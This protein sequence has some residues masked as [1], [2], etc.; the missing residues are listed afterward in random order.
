MSERGGQ[1]V[2]TQFVTMSCPSVA[3]WGGGGQPVSKGSGCGLLP[4]LLQQTV[5]GCLTGAHVPPSVLAACK[6]IWVYYPRTLDRAQVRLL[7]RV[8]GL[9]AR[10][11]HAVALQSS[12]LGLS[13]R[14]LIP[15]CFPFPDEGLQTGL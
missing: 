8:R 4:R 5:G 11:R 15:G 7:D 13:A 3:V 9:C 14:P 1:E 12:L 2:S 6:H 10:E